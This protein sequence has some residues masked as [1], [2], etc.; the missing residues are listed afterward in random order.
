M[1]AEKREAPRVAS[2]LHMTIDVE[3]RKHFDYT[4]KNVSLNGMFV[5]TENSFV[6]NL[7]ARV[8]IEFSKTQNG[9]K[10]QIRGHITRVTGDG[11]AIK[12]DRM[13]NDTFNNLLDCILAGHM[14]TS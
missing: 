10:F 6:Y 5:V 1:T 8:K 3:G 14:F 2:D 9:P 7:Q 12:F 13:S 11:F 4:A